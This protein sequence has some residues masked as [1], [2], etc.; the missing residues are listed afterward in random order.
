MFI[1]IHMYVYRASRRG[2]NNPH[3]ST[4][5]SYAWM[6]LAIHYLQQKQI[7]GIVGEYILPILPTNEPFSWEKYVGEK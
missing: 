4:L 2:C 1:C 7:M 5:T 3:N 6:L